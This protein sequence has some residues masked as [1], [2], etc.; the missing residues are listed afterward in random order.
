MN[1]RKEQPTPISVNVV[2]GEE[3]GKTPKG[4]RSK[5]LVWTVVVLLVIVLA[6]L[7]VYKIAMKG[8]LSPVG[9]PAANPYPA[10]T[11]IQ[12]PVSL[13]VEF[14]QDALR[15]KYKLDK[16]STVAY[17]DGR[18]VITV[19]YT[20]ENQVFGL[21][22][23]YTQYFKQSPWTLLSSQLLQDS[24]VVVAKNEVGQMTVTIAAAKGGQGSRVTFTYQYI[25]K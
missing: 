21:L 13:P 7:V 22:S 12:N 17:P 5:G 9:G 19:A 8:K 14:P 20:S 6:G 23:T 18:T 25:I 4:R 15:E 2:N 1:V 24:G 16:V 11:A 3:A 10:G